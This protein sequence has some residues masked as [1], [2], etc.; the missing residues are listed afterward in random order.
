[1]VDREDLQRVL[2]NILGSNEVYFQPPESVR[3]HYPVI[4]YELSRINT[5]NAN[6]DKYTARKSYDVTLIHKDPDNEIVDAILSL[7]MC[8]FDRFYVFD[9]LNHYVFTIYI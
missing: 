9:N 6:N 5:R 4:R 3:F 7:P 8:S 1:M 2:E